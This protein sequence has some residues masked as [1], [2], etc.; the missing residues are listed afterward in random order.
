MKRF[1]LLVAAALFVVGQAFTQSLSSVRLTDTIDRGVGDVNLLKDVTVA[2]LEAQRT[3]HGGRLVF[4]VDI[5]EAANGTEKASSQGVAVR[6]A[7]I[8]VRFADGR[9]REYGHAGGFWTETQAIV[10][11]AGQ[12]ARNIFYTLL[13]E[14][15]SSR[16]TAGNTIQNA[17]DST[18]TVR[19]NA[20]PHA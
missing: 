4:G 14:S 10:A 7:W 17:F 13:G 19:L 9:L 12:T 3:A 18:T 15:G 20:S 6:D 5:N 2:V 11:I 1:V 16:I 8:E